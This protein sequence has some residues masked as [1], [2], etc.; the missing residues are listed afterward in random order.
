[1]KNNTPINAMIEKLV[2]FRNERDW[3]KFHNVLTK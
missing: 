1:M 3:E 2:A